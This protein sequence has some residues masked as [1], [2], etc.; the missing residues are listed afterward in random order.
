M[1]PEDIVYGQDAEQCTMVQV[2]L[3]VKCPGARDPGFHEGRG[4]GRSVHR[5]KPV[6]KVHLK[7]RLE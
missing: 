7:G 5:P 1:G 6:S 4:V 3:C 2:G